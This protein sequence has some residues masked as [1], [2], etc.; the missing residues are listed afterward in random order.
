MQLAQAP[1]AHALGNQAALVF[2]HSA[3]DL[4]QELVV[5][6][7]AHRPVEELD[8]ASRCRDLLQQQHLMHVVP[9]Q[10]VRCRDQHPVEDAQR[11]AVA[12]PL[13]AGPL[14]IGAAVAVIAEDVL[15]RHW[16]AL[17]LG[18]PLQAIQLL[19]DPVGLG[20]ALR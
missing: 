1:P 2:R 20:L 17:R 19:G 18:T 15:V 10:P 12:Q 5:G 16:P 6:G 13:Q 4:Q 8:L 11:H 9:R 3:A 14:E 7:L